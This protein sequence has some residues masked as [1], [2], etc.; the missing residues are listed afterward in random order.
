MLKTD[1]SFTSYRKKIMVFGSIAMGKTYPGDVDI[2]VDFTENQTGA[3]ALLS[4]AH[5]YYGMFDPFIYVHTG[6]R[7]VLYTRNDEAT[8]WVPAKN[9]KAILRN[10]M[11]G[12][13]LSEINI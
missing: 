7:N 6:G 1:Q 11:A 2:F 8:G 12:R 9:A 5:R 13:P 4:L 10:A 3:T